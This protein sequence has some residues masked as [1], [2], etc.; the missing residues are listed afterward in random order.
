MIFLSI[1]R[2]KEIISSSL[3]TTKNLPLILYELREYN[4]SL[5]DQSYYKITLEAPNLTEF[6]FEFFE[7]HGHVARQLVVRN[8]SIKLNHEGEPEILRVLRLMPLLEKVTFDDVSTLELNP[9]SFSPVFL[10]K[11]RKIVLNNCN[12]VV[13]PSQSLYCSQITKIFLF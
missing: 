11:L 4:K 13:T 6:H 7:N 8:L 10:E 5:Y 9:E 1:C 2:W 12:P 3:S